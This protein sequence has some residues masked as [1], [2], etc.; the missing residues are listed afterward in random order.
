[1]KFNYIKYGGLIMDEYIMQS[2]H[3]SKAWRI[4]KRFIKKFCPYA[5]F[6]ACI[7]MISLMID[8][9]IF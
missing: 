6:A 7:A 2:R 1:M 5:A 8:I 9:F 4:T 3:S